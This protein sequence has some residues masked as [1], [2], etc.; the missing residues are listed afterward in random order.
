M[1]SNLLERLL[2]LA[3]LLHSGQRRSGPYQQYISESARGSYS[4]TSCPVVRHHPTEDYSSPSNNGN[5]NISV[6]PASLSLQQCVIVNEGLLDAS[7]IEPPIHSRLDTLLAISKS[8]T[9]DSTRGID[10]RILQD[11]S[12]ALVDEVTQNTIS[13]VFHNTSTPSAH[14]LVTVQYLLRV[15]QLNT[16]EQLSPIATVLLGVDLLI[17]PILFEC[18]HLNAETVDVIID[19]V[20]LQRLSMRTSDLSST[21]TLMELERLQQT[22]AH[23]HSRFREALSCP[24]FNQTPSIPTSNRVNFMLEWGSRIYSRIGLLWKAEYGQ[25]HD[26][27]SD[28]IHNTILETL[29]SICYYTHTPL[30]ASGRLELLRPITAILLPL[31][32]PPDK[33][34]LDLPTDAMTRR[35]ES[36]WKF[37]S[38]ILINHPDLVHTHELKTIKE[39]TVKHTCRNWSFIAN[40]IVTSVLCVCVGTPVWAHTPLPN[41]DTNSPSPLPLNEQG[42]LWDFLLFC[43]NKNPDDSDGKGVTNTTRVGL[44][45]RDKKTPTETLKTEDDNEETHSFI[46]QLTR[47]RALY[48]LRLFIDSSRIRGGPEFITW[49]KYVT[50]FEALEMETEIHLVDQTWP[51]LIELCSICSVEKNTNSRVA[52]GMPSLP[53]FTWPWMEALLSRVLLSESPT[54]RKFALFRLLSGNT[55]IDIP[56]DHMKESQT[57]TNQTRNSSVFMAKPQKKCNVKEKSHGRNTERNLAPIAILSPSFVLSVIIRSFNSLG[58]SAGT[59][60]NYESDGKIK[61]D[62]LKRYIGPFITHYIQ[63][64]QSY[65]PILKL[66]FIGLLSNQYIHQ[67][68]IRTINLVLVLR[69]VSDVWSGKQGHVAIPMEMETLDD[70]VTSFR[71]VLLNNSTLASQRVSILRSFAAILSHSSLTNN[72][73]LD[74]FL[75]LRIFSLFS[76]VK[77]DSVNPEE[78]DT[79]RCLLVWLEQMGIDWVVQT[80]ATCAESYVSGKLLLENNS[81]RE[82][83]FGLAITSLCS[84]AGQLSPLVSAAALLWPAIDAGLHNNQTTPRTR[85][86]IL[87]ESGCYHHGSLLPTPPN[88]DDLLSSCASFL[89]EQIKDISSFREDDKNFLIRN[90]SLNVISPQDADAIREDFDEKVAP[91]RSSACREIVDKRLAGLIRVC[92]VLSRSFPSHASSSISKNLHECVNNLR[93][94]PMKD[95]ELVINFSVCFAYLSLGELH[96]EA[97][98]LLQI[99]YNILESDLYMADSSR[100]SK[101]MRSIFHYAKWGSLSRIIPQLPTESLSTSEIIQFNERLLYRAKDSVSST[102]LVALLPLFEAVAS[103]VHKATSTRSNFESSAMQFMIETLFNTITDTNTNSVRAHM[104]ETLCSIIFRGH[105]LLDEYRVFVHSQDNETFPILALFR[106]LILQSSTKPHIAKTALCFIS[107]AWLFHDQRSDAG[108]SAIMYRTD[109][110]HILIGKEAEVNSCTSQQESLFENQMR[111]HF[112]GIERTTLPVGVHDMS[113]ARGFVMVFLSKLPEA[114][115]MSDIVLHDLCFFVIR[116]LLDIVCTAN[117]KSGLL[118]TGSKE[119]SEKIRAWQSL[120]LLSRFITAEIVDETFEKVFDAMAQNLHGQIRY[121]IEIFTIKCAIKHA[122]VFNQLIRRLTSPFLSL[123]H[124]SSLMII[125]GNLLLGSRYPTN[126]TKK[127]YHETQLTDVIVSVI[128]W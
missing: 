28:A 10:D 62:D 34:R 92:S 78:I 91:V 22:T 1:M 112:E 88:V 35:M 76:S 71:H 44:A 113:I 46:N 50:T 58:S 13:H 61:T 26:I 101:I 55:G 70:A 100:R 109:I 56:Q 20:F 15:I 31:L 57:A 30:F 40:S 33:D 98:I 24:L 89:I 27:F 36:L 123:Q 9:S 81:S 77:L 32:Y 37:L 119:Y 105:L 84:L 59:C 68:H 64:L 49:T 66:F 29:T 114:H 117:P 23:F 120:C 79:C 48:I 21:P 43:L 121:F 47:R 6:A 2:H 63:G 110:C 83:E 85:A 39:D 116:G 111:L 108:I 16:G 7:C 5:T 14:V 11:L 73:K 19:A 128:P 122:S 90:S 41:P 86:L 99:C 125:L 45:S 104:L 53:P 126:I 54:I 25:G 74:P 69:G 4:S 52:T 118:I 97:R 103:S 87:L 96:V 60:V 94:S 124:V 75:L 17:Y 42:I 38:S 72:P 127:I 93:N 12:H 51:T 18:S 95:E 115:E 65:P 107:A 80:T 82:R 67:D 8:T 102:P 3:D 106:M